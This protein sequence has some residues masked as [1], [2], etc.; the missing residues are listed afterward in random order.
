[1]ALTGREM[2]TLKR[3]KAKE[4]EP[5]EPLTE[6][7]LC[8]MEQR[9]ADVYSCSPQIFASLATPWKDLLDRLQG[10]SNDNARLIA[11]VRNLTP[12]AALTGE[13]SES[14]L[15]AQLEG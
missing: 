13:R 6:S 11:E 8:Q 3:L 5:T 9:I 4:A 10:V 2:E 12:N 15:K 1:M 7:D 14:E